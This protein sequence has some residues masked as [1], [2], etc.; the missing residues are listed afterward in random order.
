MWGCHQAICPR[1]ALQ[2]RSCVCYH[3]AAPANAC[4]LSLQLR[5][6]LHCRA[7]KACVAIADTAARI[8][9]QGPPICA[10]AFKMWH[11]VERVL[12]QCAFGE[13]CLDIDVISLNSSCSF[14][15]LCPSL[16]LLQACS[17][18]LPLLV[19]FAR[20]RFCSAARFCTWSTPKTSALLLLPGPA[21]S[22]RFPFSSL[23][24][25]ENLDSDASECQKRMA[26]KTGGVAM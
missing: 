23:N 24:A 21:A 17:L 4:T 12:S 11:K 6:V 13:A 3:Q 16:P 8:R 18:Q 22:T 1:E 20:L 14:L 25:R 2:P 15:V 10:M 26:S 7:D 9:C 19:L 5:A